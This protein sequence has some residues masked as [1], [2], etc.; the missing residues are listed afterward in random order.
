MTPVM[1]TPPQTGLPKR[2]FTLLEMSIVLMVLLALMSISMFGS[3]KLD[4]WK[5]GRKASEDLRSVYSAQRMYLADN[6]TASVASLTPAL[7]IPYLPNQ[8]TAMPTVKSLSGATLPVIVT[9]SPPV[10]NDGSG[11][12]YDPSGC[13]NDSLWDVGE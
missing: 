1:K 2:A 6:P 5:L 3:R 4:E 7:L 8:A 13:N 11:V 12:T 10:I 9:V